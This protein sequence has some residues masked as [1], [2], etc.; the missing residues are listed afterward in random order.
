MSN[1]PVQDRSPQ[2]LSSAYSL[3]RIGPRTFRTF[4]WP[5]AGLMVRRKNPSLVCRVDTPHP[6]IAAYSSISFAT[7]ASDSGVRPSD[8]S[9]SSLPSSMC[10]S[11]S[12]LTV[13]LRR[14]GRRGER[15]GP[16][17]HPDPERTA[18]QLLYVTLGDP[19][20]GS[21]IAPVSVIRSTKRSTGR[22]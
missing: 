10:A 16:G 20:H 5:R 7:V 9:L 17:V 12:V 14:I 21:R 1:L 3:S 13:D 22:G 4:M 11:C 6:A 15:I 18:R 2:R 19:R 8:A